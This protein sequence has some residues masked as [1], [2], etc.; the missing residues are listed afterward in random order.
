MNEVMKRHVD[1]AIRT[2]N[3]DFEIANQN[4]YDKAFIRFGKS[5]FENTM[6]EMI[7]NVDA[8]WWNGYM[9]EKEAIELKKEL[10]AIKINTLDE[11]KRK[12]RMKLG[13]TEYYIQFLLSDGTCKTY[14]EA[15][16]EVGR[17]NS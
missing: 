14:A 6:D 13:A 9:E 17:M 3:Y 2:V 16:N 12:C 10:K 4:I 11:L 7:S 15:Y 5:V 1:Q 8:I